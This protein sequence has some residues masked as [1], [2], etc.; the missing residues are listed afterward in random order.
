MN[1]RE[2]TTALIAAT[3]PPTWDMLAAPK[4][5]ADNSAELQSR[6][7]VLTAEN[8]QLRESVRALEGSVDLLQV[9]NAEL[10]ARRKSTAET[11]TG[12][13]VWMD[14]PVAALIQRSGCVPCMTFL[15][16][17]FTYNFGWSAGTSPTCHFWLRKPEQ[18]E[19]GPR[20]EVWIDGNPQRSKL[21]YENKTDLWEILYS[22]PATSET[23]RKKLLQYLP[24]GK[25]K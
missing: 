16:D 18:P 9:R 14:D 23:G 21:G 2:A 11:Y 3:V 12:I 1:R 24:K 22:H 4:R 13:V 7:D 8:E 10:S 6:I 25:M 20:F 15:R 5:P 17:L 19:P